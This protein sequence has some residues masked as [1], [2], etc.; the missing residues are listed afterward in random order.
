[1]GAPSKP[2]LL[3]RGVFILV[4][5]LC[6][7]IL[8]EAAGFACESCR[9][10]EGPLICFLQMNPSGHSLPGRDFPTFA[11]FERVGEQGGVISN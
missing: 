1:M 4:T 8:S 9:E 10:V 3:G 11:V 5:N 7:V 6:I 2:V